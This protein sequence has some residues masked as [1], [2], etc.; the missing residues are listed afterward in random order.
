MWLLWGTKRCTRILSLRASQLKQ[1]T[2]NECELLTLVSSI[3][4]IPCYFSVCLYASCSGSSYLHEMCF[5]LLS[6]WRSSKLPPREEIIHFV[7]MAR[8]YE[9][10]ICIHQ[11]KIFSHLHSLILWTFPSYVLKFNTSRFADWI[12]PRPQTAGRAFDFA[13]LDHF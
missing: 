6:I 10:L 13:W 9:T 12:G 11:Y 7:Q 5:C 2:G 3:F 1:K 4:I 8:C